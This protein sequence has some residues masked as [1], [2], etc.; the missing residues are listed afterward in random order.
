MP[1]DIPEET[2]EAAAAKDE[3]AGGEAGDDDEDE[4]GEAAGEGEEGPT[5]P[6]HEPFSFDV[7][8]TVQSQ[9]SL[10]G[11]RHNDHLRYRQYCT[12]RLRRLHSALHF[13]HGK[14]RFKPAPFPQDFNDKRFLEIP[15][16]NAERAWSYAVQLKADNAAA[17]QLNSPW[18]RHSIMRLSKAAKWARR[19]EAACKVHADQRTQLEAEAYTSFLEATYLVEKEEWS[20]AL[21]K[22]K[23]CKRVCDRLAVASGQAEAALFKAKTEELAPMLRECKYNLDIAQD[24]DDSGDEVKPTARSK[25]ELSEMSY[26]GWGLAFPSDKIKGKLIKC[27]QLA[28]SIKVSDEDES[29]AIIE[30]YGGLSAEFGDAL[31]DIHTDMINAGSDTEQAADWRMLEAFARELSIGMNIER[32]LILL[33]KHLLKLDGLEEVGSSESRRVFRPEEGMRFCDLLKEDLGTLRELPETSDA[34]STA[35]AV[36]LLLVQNCRCLFLALCHLSVGKLLEAAALMDMLHARTELQLGEALHEP[37]ARLYPLLERIQRTLPQR[38]ARWRC[39]GLAQLCA[40]GKAKEAKEAKEGKEGKEGKGEGAKAPAQQKVLG[41]ISELA[42]FPPPFRDIPCKP[43]LFD[44]AF[45]SIVAP[46]IEDALQSRPGGGQQQSFLGRVA[47][48]LGNRL[49]GFW[50]RK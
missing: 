36:Y 40:D 48:G 34:I 41:E 8:K 11:L 21:A 28:G 25:K 38:V 18:R 23:L 45:P 26:R 35:L 13:K 2:A 7:L 49:G 29:S 20:E 47:G 50:G 32:N 22:L 42:S 33:W 16:V 44:L 43:L 9:Q 39:R 3:K 31:K 15:L 24:D 14:G 5:V 12:R 10:N 37:L 30:K 46:D 1:D 17:S 27:V 6:S 4:D 19:L